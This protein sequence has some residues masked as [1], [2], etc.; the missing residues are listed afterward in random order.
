MSQLRPATCVAPEV[1]AGSAEYRVEAD[2]I[3]TSLRPGGGR[4]RALIGRRIDIGLPTASFTLDQRP[5]RHLA[6]LGSWVIGADILHAAAVSLGRQHDAGSARFIISNLADASRQVADALAASL[7]DMNH[8]VTV[9]DGDGFCHRL[10]ELAQGADR[11]CYLVGF[12]LDAIAPKL[13][14]R[15]VDGRSGPNNL[16]TVLRQGPSQG[17]HLLSWWR[18]ARRFS[19]AIGG[20]S[21]REDVAC[22]VAVNIS[23]TELGPL[24]GDHTLTWFPRPNR[25]LFLDM[26]DQVRSLIVP[27]VRPGRHEGE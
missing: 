24:I 8:D 25:S 26:H 10:A 19:E 9:T 27:F 13:T 17:V 7:A 14:A 15:G 6:A 11:P 16:Q 22:L 23:A 2:P 3:Y 1:F 20:S 21:G 12:G 5:G 18:V 4:R